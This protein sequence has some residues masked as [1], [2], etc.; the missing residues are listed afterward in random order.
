MTELELSIHQKYSWI[1]FQSSPRRIHTHPG[2]LG[3]VADKIPVGPINGWLAIAPNYH[4][5]REF[6]VF[7]PVISKCKT[8]RERPYIHSVD[9]S[10]FYFDD[11]KSANMRH[12]FWP[13]WYQSGMQLRFIK[14]KDS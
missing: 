8:G 6:V 2:F 12:V 7:Q 13:N 3:L 9:G 14:L 5:S 1:F 11:G 4:N 10:D